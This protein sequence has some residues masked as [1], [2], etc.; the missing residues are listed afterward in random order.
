MTV[1]DK[2]DRGWWWHEIMNACEAA[3]QPHHPENFY[4][5]CDVV[6]TAQ[7]QAKRHHR[8]QKVFITGLLVSIQELCFL[9]VSI[10]IVSYSKKLQ[11]DIGPGKKMPI[12]AFQSQS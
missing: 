2:E 10:M 4:S 9:T 7:P 1:A 11:V 6:V 12:E 8:P 3:E 5:L